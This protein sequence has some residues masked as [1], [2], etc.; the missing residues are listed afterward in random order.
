MKMYVY[1]VRLLGGKVP[2]R[3]TIHQNSTW[4]K[5]DKCLLFSSVTYRPKR[6]QKLNLKFEMHNK[7]PCTIMT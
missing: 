4:N 5:Q 1:T 2:E 3:K 7:Y 6:I